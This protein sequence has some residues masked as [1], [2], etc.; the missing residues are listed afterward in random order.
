[1]KTLCDFHRQ[2]STILLITNFAGKWKFVN[3][4]INA[5]ILNGI[6][7]VFVTFGH[8]IGGQL[9]T[10]QLT[11]VKAVSKIGIFGRIGDGVTVAV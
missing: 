7:S 9:C 6:T 8:F 11:R 10:L 2:Q 5:I 4:I 3:V 1:M